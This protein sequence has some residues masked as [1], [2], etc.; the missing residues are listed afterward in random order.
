MISFILLGLTFMNPNPLDLN[1]PCTVKNDHDW[2]L[3]NCP[4]YSID[5][6]PSRKQLVCVKCSTLTECSPLLAG[7]V[8]Q[9][10][11]DTTCLQW[12]PTRRNPSAP[13][14][15]SSPWTRVQPVNEPDTWYVTS[16]GFYNTELSNN[17]VF[18]EEVSIAE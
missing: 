17:P 8:Q 14:V 11:R 9:G 5:R 15:P 7:W 10:H 6:S 16:T 13:R 18:M 4:L 2:L 12:D 3:G 1:W